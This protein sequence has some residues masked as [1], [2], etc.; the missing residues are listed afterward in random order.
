MIIAFDSPTNPFRTHILRLAEESE[1][2]QEAIATL[3]T[4]NLKQRRQART[5]A[6][7]RTLPSRMSSLA[8]RALTEKSFEDKREIPMVEELAREEQYHRGMAVRALNAELADPHRRLSDSV[9]ATLLVLCLFHIC[10]TGVAQ[11]RTLFAGVKKLLAIRMR[12]G[13]VANDMKWFIR[14]FTWLDTLTAS[15]NNREVQLGGTCVDITARSGEE[16]C[17]ENLTGCDSSLFKLV[18][19]L[20]RLNLLNQNQAVGAPV[21]PDLLVST[22]ALPPSMQKPTYVVGL[23]GP[24]NVHELPESISFLASDQS[25]KR[26]SSAFWTEWFSLR[27]KLEAWRISAWGNEPVIPSQYATSQLSSHAYM[28]PPSSPHSRDLIAPQN[29][30]DVYNISESFRHSA[31]LYC[32]RLAYP[33]LPTNHPRIQSI[34]HTVIRHISAVQSDVFL[35]WPLF[36]TGSECVLEEHRQMIRTRCMDICKDSGFFNNLSCLELL[37]KIWAMNSNGSRDG[38]MEAT[39]D[40]T[41]LHASGEYVFRWSRVMQTKRADGE[42]IVV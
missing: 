32:E 24:I 20:G 27:Q 35:L 19:Q 36:I 1:S 21:A 37:E 16:W 29:L 38:T 30:S 11:F 18:A 7:G 17:L 31:I 28:S 25:R 22:T 23:P 8:L 40:G 12:A 2:L 41:P 42:Y 33:D 34:V 13:I 39:A 26:P 15:T 14:L 9:L 4:N 6:T 3:S 10:D 5:I